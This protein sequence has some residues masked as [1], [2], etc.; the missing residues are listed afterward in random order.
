VWV[1]FRWQGNGVSFFLRF[2]TPSG[3]VVGEVMR[4]SEPE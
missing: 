2:F 3:F 4:S 1:Q